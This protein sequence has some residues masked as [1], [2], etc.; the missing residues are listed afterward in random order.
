MLVSFAYAGCLLLFSGRSSTKKKDK[1]DPPEM[2]P[3]MWRAIMTMAQSHVSGPSTSR[4]ANVSEDLQSN[5]SPSDSGSGET[6]SSEPS[7]PV[8]PKAQ[9]FNIPSWLAEMV[10]EEDD[11]GQPRIESADSKLKRRVGLCNSVLNFT[12]PLKKQKLSSFTISESEPE[13]EARA[14]PLAMGVAAPMQ[15]ITE[16]LT[17]K[18]DSSNF[19]PPVHR[20]EV[21]PQ[22]YARGQS[23]EQTDALMGASLIN[24]GLEVVLKK[25][26]KPSVSGLQLSAR[27][28]GAVQHQVTDLGRPL[29]AI[30][31]FVSAT[32]HLMMQLEP[33]TLEP[34]NKSLVSNMDIL[35]EGSLYI[36]NDL[37]KG[38][39]SALA[40]LTLARRDA[41]L[42]TVAG[43]VK[44]DDVLALRNSPF[45]P[46]FL[47]D[48]DMLCQ[49]KM[50]VE[51]ERENRALATSLSSSISKGMRSSNKKNE[52]KKGPKE[53]KDS[54]NAKPADKFSGPKKGRSRHNRR[55]SKAKAGGPKANQNQGPKAKC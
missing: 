10:T 14:L 42:T 43:D 41:V 31:H 7:V 47:F 45:H 30:E 9:D 52:G 8:P 21:T 34:A 46:K 39:A 24:P 16:L 17:V 37:Y 2:T 50:R 1:Q 32:R 23:V 55:Q 28:A 49:I 27:Y 25:G 29:S 54:N 44:K 3:E 18:G 5:L 51:K 33:E 22:V 12:P 53:S 20:P 11:L 36:L 38:R 35:L 6:N 40:H 4:L 15:Q 48:P 19:F 26:S 13:A